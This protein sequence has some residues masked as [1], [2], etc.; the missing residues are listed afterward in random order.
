MKVLRLSALGTGLLYPQETFLVL[1]SVRGWVEPRATVR[2][3]GLCPWK[4]PMTL[5]GIELA[6]FRLVAQ[7]LRVPHLDLHSCII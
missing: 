2:Q 4:N 7:C 5:S 3:E 6:T 1:L